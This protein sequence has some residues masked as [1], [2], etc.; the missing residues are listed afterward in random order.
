[1]ALHRLSKYR[2]VA[3][4]LVICLTLG[5]CAGSKISQENFEKIHTGMTMA[6]VQAILGEATESSSVDVAV[7]SGAVAKWKRGDITIT[8]QFF[9]GKVV[10]K[11][12]AKGDK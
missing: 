11:Q 5:A 1:M 8:I 12:L 7:V 9:N 4:G 10:A 2:A 3:L 6:Q